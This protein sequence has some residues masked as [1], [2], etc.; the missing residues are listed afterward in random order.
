MCNDIWTA[1]GAIAAAGTL[2]TALIGVPIAFA[3]LRRARKE[4]KT[5]F[6]SSYL[7]EYRSVP[8]GN[9]VKE[10]WEFYEVCN[11][12]QDTMVRMYVTQY[13]YD[14]G[15]FHMNV[16][17]RVTAFFQQMGLLLNEDSELRDIVYSV[18]TRGDLEIISKILLPLEI[19]A[20]PRVVPGSAGPRIGERIVMVD[21]RI[22]ICQDWGLSHQVMANLYNMAVDRERKQPRVR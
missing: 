7:E 15:R 8:F 4:R 14:S 21:R 12:D 9:A 1:I 3:S 22:V 16:R 13:A 2:L 17:R 20:V 18:W 5:A 11:K 10:L 6:L 19:L